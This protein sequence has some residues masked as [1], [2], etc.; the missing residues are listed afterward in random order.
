MTQN[1]KCTYTGLCDL[2]LVVLLEIAI[3]CNHFFWKW[4]NKML[5]CCTSRNA[6]IGL[7]ALFQSNLQPLYMNYICGIYEFNQTI[8]LKKNNNNSENITK[9]HG[10]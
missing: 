3:I 10:M 5:Q 4:F 9:N 6:Y 2:H 8:A 7:R 1:P